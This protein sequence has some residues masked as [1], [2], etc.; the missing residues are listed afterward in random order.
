DV[1]VRLRQH[2]HLLRQPAPLRA[3]R[4]ER[5]PHPEQHR[6]PG[7]AQPV[8]DDRDA[9]EGQPPRAGVPGA[10]ERSHGHLRRRLP[11]TPG[12]LA[13][14]RH[15]ADPRGAG[16]GTPGLGERGHAERHDAVDGR[17]GLGHAA[18]RPRLRGPRRHARVGS[19][20]TG[21]RLDLR[22]IPDGAAAH[23]EP[24]HDPSPELLREADMLRSTKKA[25]SGR[26]RGRMGK[27]VGLALIA[28]LAACD[29]LLE[30]E[31]PGAVEAEDLENPA[32]A[33]TIVNSALGQ[34]EC[35]ITSYVVSTGLLADELINASGWL[36]INGWGWR[37]V[38]L[39]T[40]TGSCPSGRDATGLGA[41]TPLQ[42]ADYLTTDGIR[43]IE[44]FPAEAIVGDKT[45]MLGMLA[46]YG[47]YARLLLGEGFCEMAIAQG[48]LI[49]P[50]EVLQLAV[51]RFTEA[52]GHA[53]AVGNTDLALMARLGRARA[54]L[55]LGDLEGAYTDAATIPP[56]FA[57]VADYSTID[58]VRENRVYNLNRRNNYVSA[59]PDEYGDR[60]VAGV[61]DPRVE[62]TF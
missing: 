4:G 23:G 14:L 42:Q 5:R 15:P 32:L 37:G 2:V 16:G 39:E 7:H 56:G 19:R 31:N 48:P 51:D 11:A 54:L 34:L 58:G 26:G 43:L 20:G 41:Y 44:S 55:D 25:R 33:T 57:W 46:A 21:H 1:A 52:I 35:A 40:I 30:V 50:P 49:E 38:E 59:N 29:S 28:S 47:G 3:D 61:P 8:H 36:N 17:G 22:R 45:E 9:P 24:D 62:I 12:G 10:R 60:M 6:D 13:Q 18:Q 53:E 27:V